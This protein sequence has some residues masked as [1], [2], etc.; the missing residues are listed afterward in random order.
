MDHIK[1]G[2]YVGVDLG[3]AGKFGAAKIEAVKKG[4][5]DKVYCDLSIKT[6]YNPEKF[7]K[8]EHVDS[9]FIMSRQEWL[10]M[11]QKD[12][13]N[14]EAQPTFETVTRPVIK[15]LC[16]NWHPHVIA[17]VTPTNAQLLSGEESTGQIMDYVKD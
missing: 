11:H 3:Y 12:Y 4:L 7:T 14:K 15:W 13:G 6:D 1:I 5:N 10:N 17:V 8:I 9:V 16:E 2:E